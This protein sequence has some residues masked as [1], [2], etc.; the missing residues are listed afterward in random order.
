MLLM[1]L[2]VAALIFS[3]FR[4]LKKD[5]AASIAPFS[6]LRRPAGETNRL[7]VQEFDEWIDPW[8]V[9]LTTIPIILVVVLTLQRPHW[10]VVILFFLISAVVAAVAHRILSRLIRKRAAYRLGFHGERFV[11]E[12]LNQLMSDGFRVFHGVPF[13]KYN[14][15]HVLVGP[16]GVFVVETKTRRKRTADGKE[17]HKVLFDGTQ[18]NFPSGWDTEALDQARRNKKSLS[19][20]LSSATGV[21]IAAETILTIPGWWVERKGRADVY[22]VNPKE[23]RGLVL[24]LNA[25]PLDKEKIQRISHQLE[26]KCKLP[27][28]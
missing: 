28:E 6:E 21:P 11:A 3:L 25:N 9:V 26:E 12:E 22:V 13:P 27:I 16:N 20:W 1:C 23:I 14:M 24:S 8:F 7:R 18:L 19:Q 5:R 15:D 10:A 17:K 4:E 2:P